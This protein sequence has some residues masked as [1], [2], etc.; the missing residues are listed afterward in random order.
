MLSLQMIGGA[1]LPTSDVVELLASH[2][3]LCKKLTCCHIADK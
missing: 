1:D 3:T 2:D